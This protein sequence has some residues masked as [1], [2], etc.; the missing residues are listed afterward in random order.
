MLALVLLLASSPAP[1]SGTAEAWAAEGRPVPPPEGRRTAL[2]KGL[3]D[4]RPAAP[5]LRGR[6][7]GSAPAILPQLVKSWVARF[8]ALQP[9]IAIDVPPP[10]EPPQGA[11]S[12]RLAAF[13]AGRLDFA[14]LSRTMAASDV[15]A[16]R[17]T[18][19]GDPLVI[20]VA[21]G[22]WRQFGFVDPVAFI[23]NAGNPV[24]GLTFAQLDA[25]LSQSRRRGLAPLRSWGDLGVRAWRDRPVHVIGAAS[26]AGEDSARGDVVRE[27]ILLGGGWRTDLAGSAASGTEADVPARIARDP[28][29]IGFT[30]LGHLV[31]GTRAVPL[32]A[33]PRGAYVAPTFGAVARGL[34]PL[35][36]TVDLIV[37]R[38]PGQCLRP[39]L[40]AFVEY[41]LSR[42]GQQVVAQQGI[43]LPLT[44]AQARESWRR[45]S[46]C[47]AAASARIGGKPRPPGGGG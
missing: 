32:S 41:L 11:M 47:G 8:A 1:P 40:L 33:G 44:A 21:N 16:F 34:Y 42:Q 27:R 3:A 30:G 26:W 29:A 4:Y 39:E 45:A 31:A 20:P 46:A 28:L 43:F 22:S 5:G 17:R 25:L 12:S 10:Y 18:H 14:F 38:A 9:G 37:A 19:R 23:V 15:R 2:D 35:S 24:R 6:L 7:E 13:L 36:R